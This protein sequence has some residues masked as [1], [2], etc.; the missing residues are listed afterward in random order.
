MELNLPS[1]YYQASMIFTGAGV[2]QGA[3]IV[4]GGNQGIAP[5]ATIASAINAAWVANLRPEFSSSIMLA[6]T[7][8]KCGPME[9]GPF[10][11]SSSGSAGTKAGTLFPPNVSFLIRKN[12]AIGGRQGSGRIYMPGVGDSL[13]DDAG[14]VTGAYRTTLNTAWSAF[15]TALGS[16]SAPMV[17]LHSHG[18]YSKMVG[19]P[20]QIEI[21][22]VAPR[23]PTPVTDLSVDSVLATQRRRLR[24]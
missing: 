10:A 12:T 6:G 3:A 9:D 20:A 16:A 1:G 5:P 15:L 17:L 23:A 22:I 18:A 8:V 2:P 7:R 11:Y 14:N 21:V 4:F 13:A 24:G 19:D